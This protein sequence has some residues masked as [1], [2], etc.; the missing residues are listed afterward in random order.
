MH[1]REAFEVVCDG[2]ESKCICVS[3]ISLKT[4]EVAVQ[5]LNTI[6]WKH[7]YC[8]AEMSFYPMVTCLGDCRAFHSSTVKLDSVLNAYNQKVGRCYFFGVFVQSL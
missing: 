6:K 7:K 2:H 1:F 4:T 3:L 8:F 5:F